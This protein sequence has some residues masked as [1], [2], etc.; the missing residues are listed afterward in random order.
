MF[1][2]PPIATELLR[3]T[4]L[5][6]RATSR[7]MQR[8]KNALLFD[9]LVG[10]HQQAGGKH[11][12]KPRRRPLIDDDLVCRRLLNREIAGSLALQDSIHIVGRAPKQ[13]G[14]IGAVSN[15]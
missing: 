10:A 8:G 9:H 13:D 15:E 11:Q 2:L 3:R 4:E 1:A 14:Y 7:H 12:P 6:L 5:T